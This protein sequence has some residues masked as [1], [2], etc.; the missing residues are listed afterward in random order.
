[1][2]QDQSAN[3][4][5]AAEGA[6]QP[7]GCPGGYVLDPSNLNEMNDHLRMLDWD[8][9]GPVFAAERIGDGNMNMTVRARSERSSCILKQARPWV[10]KY[11]HIPAPIERAGVEAAFYSAVTQVSEVAGR[12]PRLLGFDPDAHLLWLEDM[13]DGGDLMGAYQSGGF[14]DGDCVVLTRYLS[15]LHRAEVPEPVREVFRNRAMRAL[16][17]EHQYRFPLLE[18]NGLNLEAMTPGLAERAARLMADK[19]YS[20]RVAELGRT[21]LVDGPAL[22]H[23]D[24]FPGSRLRSNRG[25]VIIDPEFCFLGAAE[26]DLGVFL[27]HLEFIGA[28]SH[29]PLVKAQYAGEVDWALVGAFAGAEIMRRLIGVAQLPLPADLKQKRAW[30]DQSRELICAY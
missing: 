21:Y 13:G 14:S 7:L 12:M 5:T 3:R 9:E 8:R 22:V 24:F 28:G 1:M 18:D 19:Q 6:C 15:A 17:H 27:A 20:D 29:W 16:N 26:Y 11:P 2:S 30:L 25:L 23:G 10:V 4:A